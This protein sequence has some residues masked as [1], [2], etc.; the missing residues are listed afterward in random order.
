MEVYLYMLGA[1]FL[2]WWNKQ[3]AFR[4]MGLLQWR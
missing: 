2:G 1:R 4:W 3:Y